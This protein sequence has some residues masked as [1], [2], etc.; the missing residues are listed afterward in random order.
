MG[1]RGGSSGT[2]APPTGRKMSVKKFLDNLSKNNQQG[3]FDTL[4]KSPLKVGKATFTQN[5]NAVKSQE[6]ILE[7]GSDKISIRF[8]NGWNPVQV[9][10]PTSKIEQSIQVVHYKDGNATAFRKLDTKS[11]KSLKNAQKNYDE[12]LKKWK[13]MTGQKDISFR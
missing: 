13:K 8:V 4:L 7:H 12:M 1:G 3:M 2:S 9:S 10:K 11:S 6:A 5:G